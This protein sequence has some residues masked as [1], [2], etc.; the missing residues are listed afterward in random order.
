M[1]Q[2][3]MDDPVELGGYQLLGRLG[4]G[5]MGVVYIGR[6]PEGDVVALK[7]VRPQYASD[8]EFRRRFMREVRIAQGMT[9]PGLV[10][11]VAADMEA[12][13]PWLAT[14]YIAGPTLADA[15][16]RHG[17]LETPAWAGVAH[18]LGTA[19]HTVH[20]AGTVHRDLKPANVLL[21]RTGPR[22][23]DFG[24]ARTHNDSALTNVG[25]AVG[26]IGYMAPEYLTTATADERA[27][28][29]AFGAVL[30]YAAT[31]RHPF[32]QG[33]WEQV[34][35]RS[36]HEPPDLAGLSPRIADLLAA[37]LDK[38]P[39]RRPPLSAA[40]RE[41]SA[42]DPAQPWLPAAILADIAAAAEHVLRLK[43]PQNTRLIDPHAESA[44]RPMFLEVVPAPRRPPLWGRLK[45]AFNGVPVDQ[46]PA[47]QELRLSRAAATSGGPMAFLAN[48]HETCSACSGRGMTATGI[49]RSCVGS[50]HLP[51]TPQS[52][53]I[54]FAPGIS[55]GAFL[56]LPGMGYPDHEG[57]RSDLYLSVHIR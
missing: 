5:G 55:S 16:I 23:I 12:A 7:V 30:A 45:D 34:Q 3:L 43:V 15:V 51:G 56:V 46:S 10:K 17:P 38:N 57:N 49:C 29:F 42:P 32:G 13:Q 44:H 28:L 50:G 54:T 47:I 36:V 14:E 52:L 53:T 21:S 37:L 18:Q 26:T 2:L 40:L 22:L 31:G 19:L 25:Q 41:I 6:G 8:S 1:Q 11:I 39:Y 4:Q 48:V 9:G 24:I 27:D 35:Y 20:E 33:R